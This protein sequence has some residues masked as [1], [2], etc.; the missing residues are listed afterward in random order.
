MVYHTLIY[1]DKVVVKQSQIFSQLQHFKLFKIRICVVSIVNRCCNAESKYRVVFCG[2]WSRGPWRAVF[3][4]N[5]GGYIFSLALIILLLVPLHNSK[6]R[7]IITNFLISTVRRYKSRILF[8]YVKRIVTDCL[9]NINE[10][11]LSSS[12]SLERKLPLNILDLNEDV[13]QAILSQ[14]SFDDIAKIR[15]VIPAT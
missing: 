2:L 3:L 8:F 15:L 11:K 1:F 5:I 4:S 7:V 9:R 10:K 12:M 14:L 13:L 6:I